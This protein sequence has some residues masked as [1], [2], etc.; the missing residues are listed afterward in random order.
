MKNIYKTIPAIALIA[1][2][3]SNFSCDK[4]DLKNLDDYEVSFTEAN[5]VMQSESMMNLAFIDVF[6][7]GIRAGAFAD[8]N[9]EQA[10]KSGVISRDLLGGTMS[11]LYPSGDIDD[12]TEIPVSVRVEWG[13]EK[14]EGADGYSRRGSLVATLKNTNWA[15]EG[16]EIS[17]NFRDYYLNDYKISGEVTIKNKGN[18]VY[19]IIVIE[20][21]LT[22]P[23][24]KI[25]TRNSDLFLKWNEGF[26]TPKYIED[27]IWYLYGNVDG[28]TVNKLDYKINITEDNYLRK[29][30]CLYPTKGVADFEIKKI[31]FTLD[32]APNNEECD[33]IAELD[34]FGIKKEITFGE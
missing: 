18:F 21:T 3:I 31:K 29:G 26:E 12:K 28:C 32:Y 16:A 22:S 5:E 10:K 24:G 33:N 34:F 8:E 23:N 15:N 2:S 9:L 14:K 4:I 25:S 1:L 7:I 6:N 30:I 27:D 17:I 19:E 13:D 20:G 11:I